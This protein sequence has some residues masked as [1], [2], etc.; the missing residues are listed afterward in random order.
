[1]RVNGALL[2]LAG[3]VTFVVA[4]VAQQQP[5]DP[6]RTPGVQAGR[7]PNR[8]AFVREHC[9]APV[10]TQAGGGGRGGGGRGGGAPQPVEFANAGV[11]AI[12]GVIAAGQ[13]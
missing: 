1:M 5:V 6:I 4:A 9:S 10:L 7:D 2:V 3:L 11:N 8:E 12:P 13:R